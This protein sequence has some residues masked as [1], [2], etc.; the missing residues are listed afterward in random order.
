MCIVF[1]RTIGQRLSVVEIPIDYVRCLE[2]RVADGQAAVPTDVVGVVL[3]MSQVLPHLPLHPSS[4]VGVDVTR[5]QL[6]ERVLEG[7]AIR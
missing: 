7:D 6:L 5:C 2:V 3:E 4:M 1:E